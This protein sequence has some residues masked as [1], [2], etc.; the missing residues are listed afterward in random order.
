MLLFVIMYTSDIVFLSYSQDIR[1]DL[2]IFAMSINDDQIIRDFLHFLIMEVCCIFVP[3]N[4]CS[5]LSLFGFISAFPY[6][7]P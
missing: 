6:V 1:L 7:Y 5:H 4:L 2:G 3:V